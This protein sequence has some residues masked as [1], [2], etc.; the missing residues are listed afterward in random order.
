MNEQ[1]IKCIVCGEDTD[2]DM[3]VGVKDFGGG[4]ACEPRA[5]GLKA[6][7]I[8]LRKTLGIKTYELKSHPPG[9]KT[10]L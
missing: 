6:A 1:I 9:R 3:S 2:Y 4:D 10:N 7:T 5:S 8:V